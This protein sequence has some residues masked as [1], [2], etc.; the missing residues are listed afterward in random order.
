M[1]L[2]PRILGAALA[3]AMLLPSTAQAQR[4]DERVE[5]VGNIAI[6]R[7]LENGR[8]DRCYA[9]FEGIG[10]GARLFWNIGRNYILTLPGVGTGEALNVAIPTPRGLLQVGGRLLPDGSRS[11][12]EFT[13]PQAQRLMSVRGTLEVDVQGTIFT[14]RLHGVTMEQVFVAV[15]NCAHS[16]RR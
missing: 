12:I 7:V 16:N 4:R 3:I 6:V 2:L 8:F 1:T 14:Y 13:A 11:V 15:E 10:L 9:H 5:R